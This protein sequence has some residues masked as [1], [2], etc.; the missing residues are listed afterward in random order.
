MAADL[1]RLRFGLVVI[2][3]NA[4]YAFPIALDHT[5]P[6]WFVTQCP[7]RYGYGYND[8]S[9]WIR[10]NYRFNGASIP[11][12]LRWLPGCQMLDWHLLAALPHDYVCDHPEYLPRPVGDGIFISVLMAIA[13][14]QGARSEERGVWNSRLKKLQSI[15]MFVSVWSWT[16]VQAVR[17]AYL[18]TTGLLPRGS[19]LAMDYATYRRTAQRDPQAGGGRDAAGG[20]GAIV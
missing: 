20:S 4:A 18:N 10:A 17:G 9:L 16:V 11:W 3:W 14:E 8:E 13:Q 15:A 19:D 7:L 5:R 1:R 2:E 12:F 6:G